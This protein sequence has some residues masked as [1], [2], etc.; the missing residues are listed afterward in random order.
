M[1]TFLLPKGERSSRR[2]WRCA[3]SAPRSFTF[4]IRNLFWKTPLPSLKTRA[5]D[6]QLF[7]DSLL[8]HPH[9]LESRL[10]STLLQLV[11][12]SWVG[13]NCINYELLA[14][15][16]NCE[17]RD[18]FKKEGHASSAFSPDTLFELRLAALQLGCLVNGPSPLLPQSYDLPR[19]TRQFILSIG[20]LRDLLAG[21]WLRPPFPRTSSVHPP[22]EPV[23]E[24][25]GSDEVTGGAT[26]ADLAPATTSS[27]R[28]CF[29]NLGW[30]NRGTASRIGN[31]FGSIL[32]S[33]LHRP[34]W[35]PP[36]HH[37]GQYLWGN[38]AG[39][40]DPL[41][42][43]RGRGTMIAP[44]AE[45][46]FL[47]KLAVTWANLAELDRMAEGVEDQLLQQRLEHCEWV[48]SLVLE[49][50]M[51]RSPHRSEDLSLM[52]HLQLEA[53]PDPH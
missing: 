23:E 12:K 42:Q 48:V 45:N 50:Q 19:K 33:S 21:P 1:H 15:F 32:S 22:A 26:S 4:R 51:K 38:L 43:T 35:F 14:V 27:L 36:R 24:L 28:L 10:S 39:L 2:R 17:L 13:L 3:S 52:N 49:L 37:L 6:L 18:N 29:T 7:I 9:T 53:D 41:L 20:Q 40:N 34:D 16:I 25:G 46:V 30:R 5:N 31:V 44:P 47:F 11:V 8:H